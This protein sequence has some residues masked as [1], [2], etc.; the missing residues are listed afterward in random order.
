MHA[1]GYPTDRPGVQYDNKDIE[2][3]NRQLK[4]YFNYIRDQS[5]LRQDFQVD[6]RQCRLAE[7]I[8]PQR[9]S[10]VIPGPPIVT[11]PI[12]HPTTPGLPPPLTPDPVA[13]P[14]PP[15]STYPV[16]PPDTRPLIR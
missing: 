15:A 16:T 13:P 5:S 3:R 14:T 9:E 8:F 12:T 2:L 4:Y 10:P 11:P 7:V 1:V 6:L